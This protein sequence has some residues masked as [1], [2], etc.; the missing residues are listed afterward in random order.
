MRVEGGTSNMIN[1]VSRQPS[2]IRLTSQ[3]EESINQF[4]TLTGGLKP[5]NPTRRIGGLLAR[6]SRWVPSPI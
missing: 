3:L 5:R 1:G 2:E 6:L 4:P